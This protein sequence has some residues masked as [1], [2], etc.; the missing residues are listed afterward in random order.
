MVGCSLTGVEIVAAATWV[1]SAFFSKPSF[2]SSIATWKFVPPNPK[3][4]TLA[5]RTLSVFHGS[6]LVMTRKGLV[7][8][9]TVG[10][11][12]TK[13]ADGGN[14]LLYKAS[15]VLIKE[16]MPAAA[17]AWPIWLF[18][19]PSPIVPGLACG[20][21]ISYKAFNSTASPTRV[22]V[23]C[24]S[25]RPTS[26]GVYSTCSKAFSTAI[27]CP[28]GLGAVM[29]FPFPSEDAPTARM[30]AYTRSPSFT[31]SDKRF[32]ITVPAPSAMTKPSALASN[33]Q[34]PFSDSAP[35]LQ[36]LI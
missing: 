26:P 5:R 7:A 29:P 15:D 27:F 22:L 28:L 23:P 16:A 32:K 25:T 35:I 34:E 19:L 10:F 8:Q 11:G 1:A 33:G 20:P 18:T 2:I 3:A 6:A 30:T 21:K 12:V 4:D 13:L 9:S 36:N 31:A 14:T 24:A 17:L